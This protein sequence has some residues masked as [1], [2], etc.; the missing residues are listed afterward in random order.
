MIISSILYV[1]ILPSIVNGRYITVEIDDTT[2][3]DGYVQIGRV[4]VGDGF[5]A[6]YDASLDYKMV[7]KTY[8]RFL[9]Q[10]L[11]DFVFK[12]RRRRYTKILV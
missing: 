2:N 8:H 5:T 10:N 11:V 12:R 4:F 6:K 3:A 7:G 9:I 1:P